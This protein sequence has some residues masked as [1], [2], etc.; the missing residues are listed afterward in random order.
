[1]STINLDGRLE[2]GILTWSAEHGDEQF[3][4]AHIFSIEGAYDSHRKLWG[5]FKCV[6]YAT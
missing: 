4:T 3:D 1:M 2:R 6:A 5:L